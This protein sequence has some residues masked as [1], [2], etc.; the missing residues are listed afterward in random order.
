VSNESAGKRTRQRKPVS[1]TQYARETARG[2]EEGMPQEGH[3][4]VCLTSARWTIY[5]GWC[6][7]AV[8]C[9]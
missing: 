1:E 4:M 9:E 8:A 5:L 7:R 3:R 6:V 2:R